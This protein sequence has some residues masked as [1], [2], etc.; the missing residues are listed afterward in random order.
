M[1]L[2][3]P[4]GCRSRSPTAPTRVLVVTCR[5]IPLAPTALRESGIA[6]RGTVGKTSGAPG[7]ESE[8]MTRSM[9]ANRDTDYGSG[10]T[11]APIEFGAF[12]PLDVVVRDPVKLWNHRL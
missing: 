3:A 10:V 4:T 5:Q 2:R 12:L 1:G 6:S 9:L 8:F 7:D 11:V